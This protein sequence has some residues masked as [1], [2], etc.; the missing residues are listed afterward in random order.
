MERDTVKKDDVLKKAETWNGKLA[1]KF[2]IV[3]EEDKEKPEGYD[4]N[5]ARRESGT[6]GV[7]LSSLPKNVRVRGRKSIDEGSYDPRRM[8]IDVEENG[9]IEFVGFY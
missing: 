4:I 2:L 1:G 6:A 8:N 7:L 9:K 3:D 5:R